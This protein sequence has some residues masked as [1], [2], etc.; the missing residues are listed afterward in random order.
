M[1]RRAVGWVWSAALLAVLLGVCA[2][3]CDRLFPKPKPTAPAGESL[4]P[5][6]ANIPPRF[7]QKFAEATRKDPPDDYPKPPD[8][9]MA[10]KSVGTVHEQVVKSWSGIRF[11]TEDGKRRVFHA[12]LDTELGEIDIELRPDWAPNHVRSFVALAQAGFYDG[13]VFEQT[14]HEEYT[15]E[16]GQKRVLDLIEGGCPLGTGDLYQ[17]NV[18]YWLKDEIDAKNPVKQEEGIVGAGRSEEPDTNDCRFYVLLCKAPH[19]DGNYTAFGKVCRG[20]DVA[21]KIWAQPTVEVE[22]LNVPPRPKKPVVIRKV[23][24]STKEVDKTEPGGDN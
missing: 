6:D 1:S 2:S 15:G 9:T 21:R 13:L 4:D 19:F 18:G 10:G 7:R 23:T 20:L 3:G 12:V 14:L 16:D 17:S 5:A 22:D 8:K 11:L 24:V